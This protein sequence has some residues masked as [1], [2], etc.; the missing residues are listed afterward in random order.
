MLLR[1]SSSA[2]ASNMA[3]AAVLRDGLAKAGLP[4]D[5]VGLVEDTSR[6]AAVAFMQLEGSS[7]A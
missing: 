2:L 7:T 4:A 1:G 6:E 3:I 5:A